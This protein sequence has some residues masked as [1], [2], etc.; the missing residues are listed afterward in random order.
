MMTE[1]FSLWVKEMWTAT[2]S[3]AAV[4]GVKFSP[5]PVKNHTKSASTAFGEGGHATPG[6]NTTDDSGITI[7]LVLEW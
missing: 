1:R 7:T 6:F 3:Q 2:L 5:T 4:A